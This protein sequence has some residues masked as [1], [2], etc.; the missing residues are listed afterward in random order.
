MDSAT[1]LQII[2]D[3]NFL[4]DEECSVLTFVNDNPDFNG[5]PDSLIHVSGEWTKYNDLTFYG[6]SLADCLRKAVEAKRKAAHP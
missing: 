2:S 1:A 5:L 3:I 6:D 4:R